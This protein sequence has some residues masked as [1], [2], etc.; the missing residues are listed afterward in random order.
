MLLRP[1]R[2]NRFSEFSI[3]HNAPTV[4]LLGALFACG[5]AISIQSGLPAIAAYLLLWGLSYLVI[6]AGTCRYC[7]Y[8]GKRCPIPLEGSCVD[9][10]FPKKAGKFGYWQLFWATAAYGLRI[11]VPVWVI[12]EYR[13]VGWGTAFGTILAGFW[14]VHLRVT[15]CPNCINTDCPLNPEAG[16]MS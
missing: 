10:V 14:I 8:Y 13:L 3:R 12:L 5:L 2:K 16:L 11:L 7:A 4:L 15:G 9:R 1:K 6:F